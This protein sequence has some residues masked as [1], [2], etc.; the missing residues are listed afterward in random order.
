M[1]RGVKASSEKYMDTETKESEERAIF[2]G[3]EID[4]WNAV[5]WPT[6][7]SVS[8]KC[9]DVLTVKGVEVR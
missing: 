7:T 5:D 1:T 3:I 9:T 4:N 6:Y 2:S 8:Q